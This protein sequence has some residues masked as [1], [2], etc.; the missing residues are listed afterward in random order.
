MATK[1]QIK[2]IY[3]LGA[4]LGIVGKDKDDMLHELIFSITGKD[5][6]KQLDDSEF[7]VVQ[8]ELI[9]RMKLAD[10]NHLLHN[11]K[12]RNKKKEAEE[13]GCNGMAT[14]EQQRLCWR[15]C[16][17]LKELDTNPESADV[18]DRLIGG[19]NKVISTPLDFLNGILNDIRDIEIAGFT[20]FDEFW[21]YDP[22]PV[23]Q[24]PMLATGAVIP[25]N[26]E[27]LAVLG[28]Q[29]RGTNIEAPLDTIK[30]AL[31]EA[32]AVYGGAV[33]NQKISVTIPIE[34]KG[35]VLSQIVIDDINDFIKRNGKSPIKV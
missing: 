9:N 7:K 8:A 16:Y 14:P 30:Q 25:P 18:G 13:I 15:Y 32:L 21:D 27:F 29:K 5:S 6:V 26:S 10:P 33:G 1:E 35:R 17:R 28:D 3:G 34:V 2:R 20:P 19:I 12:S 11:T 31:F 23:P 4:G 24:I 22:I